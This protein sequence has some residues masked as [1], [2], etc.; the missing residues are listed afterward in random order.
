MK[1][2]SISNP[3]DGRY[4]KAIYHGTWEKFVCLAC[5]FEHEIAVKPAIIEWLEST[6]EI[7]DFTYVEKYTTLLVKKSVF[8]QIKKIDPKVVAGDVTF[9]QNEKLKH[10]L[11]KSSKATKRVW[12]P[13]EGEK[14]LEIIVPI[15]I[16]PDMEKS[17]VEIINYC[18]NCNRTVIKISDVEKKDIFSYASDGPSKT[19]PRKP[20]KG[21]FIAEAS[22]H[23]INLF[24]IHE[25]SRIILCTDYAKESLE[26]SGYSNL[27]FLDFGETF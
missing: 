21:I 24:R 18:K 22:I 16:T 13:Y 9:Y 7:G 1:L 19:I 15:I 23:G 6:S 11:P 12:L 4:A 3:L 25:K 17:S 14:L 10:P 27:T 26:A 2:W 20:G 8:S 5:D